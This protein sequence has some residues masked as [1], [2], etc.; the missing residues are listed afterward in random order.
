MSFVQSVAKKLHFYDKDI[1]NILK[2]RYV[3]DKFDKELI[4]K[5]SSL[6]CEADSVAIF[7]SSQSFK[8]EEETYSKAQWYGTKY[9]VTPFSESLKDL[10]HNPRCP[11]A[12]KKLDLPPKNN[13]I[14]KNFD[15]LEEDKE[16]SEKAKLVYQDKYTDLWYRKDDEFLKPKANVQMKIYT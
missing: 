9:K 13:M 8:S 16:S 14:P 12:S 1:Q 6:L 10:I 11:I 3:V 7:L 4:Q 5:Y 15:I 2:E